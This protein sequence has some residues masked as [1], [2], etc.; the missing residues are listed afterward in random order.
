M[1]C[2]K[3]QSGL[4]TERWNLLVKISKCGRPPDHKR[5]MGQNLNCN[6]RIMV[7][8]LWN[9]VDG[10]MHLAYQSW[11]ALMLYHWKRT[12]ISESFTYGN[13]RQNTK[14]RKLWQTVHA[15]NR[16]SL[17]VICSCTGMQIFISFSP[18]LL[19]VVVVV[20]GRAV[21]YCLMHYATNQQVPG[22][23]P[24]GVIGICQWH[25]PSSRTMALGS[26]QPLTEMST[27]FVSWG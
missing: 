5:Q 2:L 11:I 17:S 8:I 25:N 18:V 24:D 23:I 16:C 6:T 4:R 10:N 14:F 20:V 3:G 13:V 7:D 1:L 21:A 22:S 26:T 15:L 12:V 27:R 9:Y 19:V